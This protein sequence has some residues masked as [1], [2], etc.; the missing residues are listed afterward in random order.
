MTVPVFNRL[1]SLSSNY[2][3]IMRFLALLLNRST[4]G[5]V[6]SFVQQLDT[7]V[8]ELESE[9]REQIEV[10]KQTELQLSLVKARLGIVLHNRLELL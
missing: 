10:Q 7:A 6:C 8:R 5:N 2:I 4:H 9:V 1:P 3:S